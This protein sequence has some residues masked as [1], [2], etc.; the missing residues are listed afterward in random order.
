MYTARSSVL[1]HLLFDSVNTYNR[2]SVLFFSG[3]VWRIEW[4]GRTWCISRSYDAHNNEA[5]VRSGQT[6]RTDECW[7]KQFLTSDFDHENRYI[8]RTEINHEKKKQL[9]DHSKT[10]R[11]NERAGHSCIGYIRQACPSLASVTEWKEALFLH[12]AN[13]AKVSG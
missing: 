13:I 9:M 5:M 8:A 10:A 12:V 2:P 7:S 4:L 11:W 3:S 1:I 6:S